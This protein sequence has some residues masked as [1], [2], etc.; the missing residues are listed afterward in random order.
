MNI[1]EIASI[2][3]ALTVI[4]GCIFKLYNL[5]RRV[6]NK[7]DSYDKNL[8][9]LNLHLNKMALLDTNLPLVD[10]LKAGELY[11]AHG[12]NGLGKKIYNQ[13][14]EGIDTSS[15]GNEVWAESQQ[16]KEGDTN[17]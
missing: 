8:E 6:E 2:I 10:R 11:I 13:L 5:A 9:Q 16:T 15:W 3:T 7:L 14:L 4:I 12:G 17:A 1:I